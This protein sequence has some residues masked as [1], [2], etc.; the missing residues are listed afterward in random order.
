MQIL[1]TGPAGLFRDGVASLLRLYAAD[2]DLRVR[3]ALAGSDADDPKPDC[4]VMDG[5]A[6]SRSGPEYEALRERARAT[7]LVV[8]LGAARRP[9]IDGLIAD[10]VAGCVEKSAS[11]DVLFGALRVAL[12]GGVYFPRAFV[13]ANSVAQGQHGDA[14]PD[15]DTHARLTPRQIEVLALLAR[16]R[17]N[18]MIARELDCAEATVKTHLTTIFKALN[19]ASRGEASAAAARMERVRETQVT[20][21]ID[22]QVSLGRLLANME[23]QRYRA[24][25][26][27][28]RKG[29]ASGELFYV[30]KGTVKLSELGIELGAGT[31]LGEIGL[32][33]PGQRRTSTVVCKTDCEMRTV[34]AAD[35]IRLYY[36]EPEFALHLLRLIVGRLQADK[37][38]GS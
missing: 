34:G 10:G 5:D 37:A 25:E 26:I 8:L 9:D 20:R 7:P 11:S 28:F 16:G 4:I 6:L 32:F 31:V 13:A 35:A 19:V 15:P 23:S 27:L 14:S 12:A 1:L 24:G 22:G 38:R 21:A 3:D 36:Q 30:E 33:S 18:K 29:D 2:A 17:S